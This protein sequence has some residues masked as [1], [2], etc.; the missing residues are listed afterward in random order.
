M[1]HEMPPLELRP[2]FFQSVIGPICHYV[3]AQHVEGLCE[4]IDEYVP[5]AF[6]EVLPAY[7]VITQNEFDS[8][9]EALH[10]ILKV[11]NEVFR[12]LVIKRDDIAEFPLTI[13][14]SV[15]AGRYL[16]EGKRSAFKLLDDHCN[17][18]K[19]LVFTVEAVSV[20]EGAFLLASRTS[21][22]ELKTIEDLRNY[23]KLDG[24]KEA[25]RVL[26]SGPAGFDIEL[27]GSPKSPE[28]YQEF[29]RRYEF[30]ANLED[31]RIVVSPKL[32]DFSR[33][34]RK[35]FA[36]STTSMPDPHLRY[37][38]GCPAK[39]LS[40]N[41]FPKGLKERD[42]ALTDDQISKLCSG[43]NP[44]AERYIRNGQESEVYVILR[45]I[46]DELLPVVDRH[47]ACFERNLEM[48]ARSTAD[49][50]LLKNLA[51]IGVPGG[52]TLQK[53]QTR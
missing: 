22:F 15:A 28:I 6:L 53:G 25:L 45:D 32:E 46:I 26:M 38:S 29:N 16:S 14:Q 31:G 23:M 37:S 30:L 3:V 9:R 19:E 35:L 48:V 10:R 44:V 33:L 13:E 7:K 18:H 4:V 36:A 34:V 42:L 11:S 39:N 2:Q 21:G 1:N 20:I 40:F 8:D 43:D 52:L 5:V 49:K 17:I 41:R 12:K 24:F 50:T 27:S 47:L 51:A